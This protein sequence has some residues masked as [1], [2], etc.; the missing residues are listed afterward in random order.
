LVVLS[1]ASRDPAVYCAFYIRQNKALYARLLAHREEI[2]AAVGATLE[3]RDVPENKSSQVVLRKN[4]D[5][6]DDAQ[7]PQLAQWLVSA[8][9]TFAEVFPSYL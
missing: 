2:E 1:I 7:A 5:W 3:W 4:G 8:A 9:D 6:R